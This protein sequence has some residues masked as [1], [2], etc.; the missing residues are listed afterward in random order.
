MAL[1]TDSFKLGCLYF[2]YAWP[3][4]NT[5]REKVGKTLQKYAYMC[6][7]ESKYQSDGSFKTS[8]LDDTMGDAFFY[9]VAFLKETGYFQNKKCFW[10]NQS[11]S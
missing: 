5:M 1:I 3:Y 9:G 2:R 10:T 6:L 11:F 7:S 4:L 8:D